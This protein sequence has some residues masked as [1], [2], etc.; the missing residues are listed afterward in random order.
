MWTTHRKDKTKYPELDKIKDN[1][2]DTLPE[3]NSPEEIDAFNNFSDSISDMMQDTI[4]GSRKIVWVNDDRMYLNEK[5]LRE[6]A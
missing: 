3:V 4:Y 5:R 2:S 6:I 1:N